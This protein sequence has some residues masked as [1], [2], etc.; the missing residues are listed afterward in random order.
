MSLEA[1]I[2]LEVHAQLLTQSK[3]FCSC[4]TIYG[5]EPNTQTCPICLGMPGTLPVINRGAVELAIYTALALHCQIAT[6]SQFARKNYFYPDLPKG[7]QITQYQEP[8]ATNGFLKIKINEVFKKIRINRL[9][10]EE[11]AGKSLH[12]E[13]TKMLARRP[14]C[15][16]QGGEDSLVDL[17]RCG[18]PLMEIITEPDLRSPQE[19]KIFLLTLRQL[20]QYL[21]VCDGDLEK[22]SFRCD[23]NVSL[24]RSGTKELGIRTEAKNLNSFR[25]VERTLLFEIERQRKILESGGKIIQETLQWDEK[26]EAALPARSKEEAHDYRYFPEPD[27][28]ELQIDTNWVKNIEKKIPELPEEIQERFKKTYKL[29]DYDVEILTQTKALAC[30][31]E[32]CVKQYPDAKIVSNWLMTEVLAILKEKK[33]SLDNFLVKPIDLTEMFELIEQGEITRTSAKTLFREMA[34]TG[35]KASLLR[36]KLGLGQ[37]SDA[38]E[39]E[40]IVEKV[41]QKQP[42]EIKRYLQ[43]KT[44]LLTFFIGQIMKETQGKADPKLVNEVLNKRL[45]ELAGKY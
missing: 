34:K 38:R 1:V 14:T 10:L 2:G 42:E 28:V 13:D 30:Y 24:R 43:G 9:Q 3:M 11:D 15:K 26:S 22:G 44:Q 16:V 8:L 4:R 12:S 41:L 37:I 18:V 6:V 23:V 45:K 20:L 35:E 32:E 39:I 7:Y 19:A 27:L 33:I 21:E 36:K 17:N 5:A 29:P 40:N 31:F 25:G